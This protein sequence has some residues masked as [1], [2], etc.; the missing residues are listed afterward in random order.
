[1]KEYRT[2]VNDW[3]SY[4]DQLAG[5]VASLPARDTSTNV[6]T[7]KVASAAVTPPP[8][9]AAEPKDVL[10]LSKSDAGKGGAGGGKASQ[11][12]IN[13]LQ[14]EVTSKDKALKESQSRVADLEK[15]I[16]DM[17]RLI[18]LQKGMAAKPG[19]SKVAT[20]PPP[21]VAEVAPAKA[22]VAPAKAG[23]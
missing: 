4:R 9:P 2:H 6:A 16:R 8:A 18:D 21:K 10:K 20:A 19:D 17:Q 5:G 3:K 1:N 13:A 22:E 14:E 11:D 7:G 12:R 15:Q 23:A